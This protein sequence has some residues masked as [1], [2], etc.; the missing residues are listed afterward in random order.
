MTLGWAWIIGLVV[1]AVIVGNLMLLKYS[2][3]LPMPSK[4]SEETP[5]AQNKPEQQTDNKGA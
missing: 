4:R 5:S 2:A 1:F 3:R